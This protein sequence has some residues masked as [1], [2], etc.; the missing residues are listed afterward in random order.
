M[1]NVYIAAHVFLITKIE[2]YNQNNQKYQT[3]SIQF[4]QI[5]YNYL[6]HQ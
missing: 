1:Q 4:I 3:K 2:S 6:T 5:L